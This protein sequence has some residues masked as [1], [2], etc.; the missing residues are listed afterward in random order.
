M[1][2]SKRLFKQGPKVEMKKQPFY[3]NKVAIA[4]RM[5]SI[6]N[7]ILILAI[8]L[9]GIYLYVYLGWTISAGTFLVALLGTFAI[10]II[11]TLHN[12]AVVYGNKIYNKKRG[13]KKHE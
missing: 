13:L 11:E 5:L 12:K 10:I 8:F 1:D 2:L 7:I 9:R 3:R 6:L 4:L